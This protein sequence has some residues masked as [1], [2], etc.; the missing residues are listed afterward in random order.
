MVSPNASIQRQSTTKSTKKR[1]PLLIPHGYAGDVLSC[2]IQWHLQQ[3]IIFSFDN[4]THE[5]K[6]KH[7]GLLKGFIWNTIL[8]LMER[9]AFQLINAEEQSNTNDPDKQEMMVP[10]EV[11]KQ[12]MAD[13]TLALLE[14]LVAPQATRNAVAKGTTP[15]EMA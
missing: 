11:K 7:Y 4:A 14:T 2:T 3:R 6:E 15:N 5:E 9:V 12:W 8:G 13:P 10:Q 1:L